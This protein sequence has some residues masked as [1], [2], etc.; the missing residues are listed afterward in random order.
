MASRERMHSFAATV[1][2]PREVRL[3]SNE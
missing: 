2:A 3:A 1:A